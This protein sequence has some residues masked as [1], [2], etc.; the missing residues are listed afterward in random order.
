MIFPPSQKLRQFIHYILPEPLTF[1]ISA[2]DHYGKSERSLPKT[3]S[4]ESA[5]NDKGAPLF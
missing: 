5:G 1:F 3:F 4:R 2:I